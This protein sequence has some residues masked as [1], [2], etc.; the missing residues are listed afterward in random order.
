EVPS[1]PFTIQDLPVVTGGGDARIVVRDVLGRE[2]VVYL[3]YYASPRLLQQGL[4]DFSYEI[5]AVRENFGI[6]SADYG[7]FMSAA[8][9]RLGL[10]PNEPAPR[11]ISQAFASYSTEGY[12]S[13]GVNYVHRAFRDRPDLELVSASYGIGLARFAFVNFVV[14]RTLGAQPQ[15]SASVLLSI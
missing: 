11:N 7:R 8:T 15:S 1:G 12:G 14:L 10:Q 13:I 9:H 5:G 6:T 2:R 3:P 4:H